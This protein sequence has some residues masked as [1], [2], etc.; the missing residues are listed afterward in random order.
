LE[1]S[2]N[3][4]SVYPRYSLGGTTLLVAFIDLDW[5]DELDDQ[6]YTVGYVFNLGSIPVSWACKK[7]HAI[8]I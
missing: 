1:S 5:E 4:T 3:D 8:V 7:Q 2:K 6:K